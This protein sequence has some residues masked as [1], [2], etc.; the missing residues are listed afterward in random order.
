MQKEEEAEREAAGGG[1]REEGATVYQTV[2]EEGR[3]PRGRE[4][5]Q[6]RGELTIHNT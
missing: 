3:R 2:A 5:P 1:R 6:Q 4:Q